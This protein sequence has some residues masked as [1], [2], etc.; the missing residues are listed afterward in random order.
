M[1]QYSDV[2][3]KSAT[4]WLENKRMNVLESPDLKPL[5]MLKTAFQMWISTNFNEPKERWKEERSK[6]CLSNL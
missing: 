1:Q 4:E 5:E 6:I 3:H 2:K